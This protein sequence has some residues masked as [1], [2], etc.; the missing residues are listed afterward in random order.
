MVDSTQTAS[1]ICVI[2]MADTASIELLK[3][4]IR[5]NTAFFG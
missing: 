5:V 3:L 4:G 2:E 1:K